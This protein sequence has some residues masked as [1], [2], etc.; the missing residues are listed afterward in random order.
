MKEKVFHE[1][2]VCS[3]IHQIFIEALLNASP[4]KFAEAPAISELSR[5]GL[6]PQEVSILTISPLRNTMF[7]RDLKEQD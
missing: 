5:H 7:L 3:F 6:C 1:F 2:I 4:C